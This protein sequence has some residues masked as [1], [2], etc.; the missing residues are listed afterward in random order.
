MR[1]LLS[2]W[3]ALSNV[4]I[5]V[6]LVAANISLKKTV[7]GV[8]KNAMQ[9]LTSANDQHTD[10]L[11]HMLDFV[12]NQTIYTTCIASFAGVWLLLNAVVCWRWFSKPL[13]R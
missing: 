10:F 12:L 2:R 8:D 13:R 3:L 1:Y 11:R 4:V 5:A 7:L 9:M 6:A